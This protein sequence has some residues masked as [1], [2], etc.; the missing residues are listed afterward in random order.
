MAMFTMH[1]LPTQKCSMG[2]TAVEYY[3]VEYSNTL[4]VS[5]VLLQYST[6]STPLESILLVY[7]VYILVERKFYGYRAMVM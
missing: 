6:G 5:R 1:C 2:N 4:L 3:I 7:S